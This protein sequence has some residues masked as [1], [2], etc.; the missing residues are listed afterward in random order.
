[1]KTK[2]KATFLVIFS[3]HPCHQHFFFQSVCMELRMSMCY[4]FILG[5]W[6]LSKI[7]NKVVGSRNSRVAI[8]SAVTTYY[9]EYDAIKSGGDQG[10]VRFRTPQTDIHK[11][12]K[13]R[14]F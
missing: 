10:V 11:R 1:M 3:L 8:V 2:L 13:T 5:D 7:I 9:T 14:G 6:M 4:E 12:L